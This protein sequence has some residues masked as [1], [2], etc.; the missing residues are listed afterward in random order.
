MTARKTYNSNAMP[1][2]DA[3]THVFPPFAIEQRERISATDR[4]F[5][6]I[7]GSPRSRMVDATGLA[8]YMSEGGPDLV[9]AVGFPFEDPDLIRRCNDYLLE[10]AE[11]DKRIL[12]L[13]S[14]DL[15]NE[16]AA[17]SEAERCLALGARGVGELAYYDTGFSEKE[18]QSLSGLA[19]RLD[20]NG[21][22]LMLHLNEQVGHQY[23]GKARADFASVAGFV[24]DHPGL[25]IILAHMGGGICFYEFMPEIKKA[26]S[27]VYYDLAAAPFLYSDELY[28][29]AATYLCKKVLLGSDY[30]LLPLARYAPRLDMLDEPAKSNILYENGRS[31]FAA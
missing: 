3:H 10:T 23:P 12:P 22:I 2:L 25:R 14:V 16:D 1:I 31:L 28:T 4:A 20:E 24:A 6:V 21:G 26:F 18:R 19:T 17:L 27:H 30:P 5:S 15:N 29:F 7:Y 11:K 13:I 8:Q 9:V